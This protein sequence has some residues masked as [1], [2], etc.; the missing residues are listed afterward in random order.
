MPKRA[1]L[2][3]W[4]I[5]HAIDSVSIAK[6]GTMGLP[7]ETPFLFTGNRHKRARALVERGYLREHDVQLTPPWPD[8]LCVTITQAGIDAYNAARAVLKPNDKAQGSAAC[9]ASP[10]AKGSTT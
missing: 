5:A 7:S 4:A 9:G 6:A 1:W 2:R 10:G 8:A 3:C